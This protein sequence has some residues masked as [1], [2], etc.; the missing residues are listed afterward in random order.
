MIWPIIQLT[1][2]NDI[3][4]AGWTNAVVQLSMML[5]TWLFTGIVHVLGYPYLNRKYERHE[6]SKARVIVEEPEEGEEEEIE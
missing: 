5:I 6:A 3:F 1:T 2:L 4:R